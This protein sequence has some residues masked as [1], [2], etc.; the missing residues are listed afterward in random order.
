MTSQPAKRISVVEQF[1]ES[2]ADDRVC[3]DMII[4]TDNF[5]AVIDGASDATGA[6]FAGKSGG[7]LAAEIIAASIQRLSVDV[8]A[9]S[10][11]DT[12]STAL[13]TA[14]GDLA[15]DVRWP[16]AVVTCVSAERREVWRIGDCHVVIDGVEHASTFLID[17][18]ASRF[19]AAVNAALIAKGTPIEEILDH[20]PGSQA[21]RIL[22]DN[23]QH[24]A[25]TTG[26][27]GYGCINGKEVPSEH[28]EVF[29]IREGP[30]EIIL[31]TDGYTSVRPT[32]SETEATL[33]RLIREDPAA[34][35]ELW[36]IGKSARP[37]SNAP[38]D[39]AYL[40]I[41]LESEPPSRQPSTTPKML[42]Y[43]ELQSPAS[44]ATA[45]E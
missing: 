7:R 45:C 26:P 2:K 30:T 5:A 37:G 16:V 41:K 8:D 14:V 34:I 10:F 3:E 40:R 28:I 29:P 24:L 38:D 11:A 31:T 1:V 17:N 22:T 23:Q 21:R 33:S 42:R 6:S 27:W 35:G 43:L 32:L 44:S 36:P 20:D 13:C 9:R 12:L 4:I 18:A 25:N 15:P 19:R 39:R